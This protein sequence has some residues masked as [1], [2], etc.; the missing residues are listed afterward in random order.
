MSEKNKKK[1]LIVASIVLAIAILI[2]A[3][4]PL[5]SWLKK[6]YKYRNNIG[7]WQAKLY[8]ESYTIPKYTSKKTPKEHLEILNTRLKYYNFELRQNAAK[9]FYETG[10]AT[11]LYT[12]YDEN[13]Q[14]FVLSLADG[15]RIYGAI[16]EEE[17]YIVSSLTDAV[18]L[19]IDLLGLHQEKIY[20]DN[21]FN[22]FIKR[23]GRYYNFGTSYEIVDGEK[24]YFGE[25][26]DTPTT[27]VEDK[28]L[29]QKKMTNIKIC[30]APYW[31]P[32]K[33][34]Q[35][36]IFKPEELGG[37]EMFYY[38]DYSSEKTESEHEEIIKSRSEEY[39]NS[40]NYVYDSYSVEFFNNNDGRQ[41]FFV[42]NYN[43]SAYDK[44]EKVPNLYEI[45]FICNDNYYLYGK[46]T[47]SAAKNRAVDQIKREVFNSKRVY[48]ND[49]PIITD[50]YKI[51]GEHERI[52]V[53][54]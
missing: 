53:N 19:S 6:E 18:P 15:C 16:I 17:Y 9:E 40:I 11:L 14:F 12:I 10:S 4:F 25:I 45:G 42:V 47:G 13:P 49:N 54:V 20:V 35:I 7:G 52:D 1:I 33:L 34:S 2:G 32:T 24:Q 31:Y 30:Q 23:D 36:P 21:L 3:L 28:K 27:W 26:S 29:Y 37:Y 46:Y 22:L 50:L 8:A 38:T 48:G 43:T 44:T 39:F 41:K 5:I 51:Y